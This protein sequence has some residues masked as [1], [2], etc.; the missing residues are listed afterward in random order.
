MKFQRQFYRALAFTLFLTGALGLISCGSD[1]ATF[2][3]LEFSVTPGKPV[4]INADTNLIIDRDG[5]GSIEFAD[6]D[7]IDLVKKPWILIQPT[8]VNNTDQVMTVVTIHFEILGT[9]NGQ[10]V[11]KETTI[12]PTDLGADVRILG[13][14]QPGESL[15]GA[16][17]TYNIGRWYIGE[18]PFDELDDFQ[19]FSYTIT[20]NVLGWVGAF[21]SDAERR[22]VKTITFTTQ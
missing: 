11:K 22:I 21:N 15:G 14:L 5:D 8:V 3:K 6:G 20:A 12:N 19:S 17:A 16:T 7:R 4:V 2:E 13:E 9:V 10:S 1:Q 18:L